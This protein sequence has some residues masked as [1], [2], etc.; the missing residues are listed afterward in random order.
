MDGFT[1]LWERIQGESGWHQEM[2][3]KRGTPWTGTC[4]LLYSYSPCTSPSRGL[5]GNSSGATRKPAAG[6]TDSS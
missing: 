5:P 4:V 6:Y 1:L 2:L 3:L